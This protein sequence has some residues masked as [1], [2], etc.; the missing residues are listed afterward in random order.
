[1]PLNRLFACTYFQV[2]DKDSSQDEVYTPCE[3]DAIGAKKVNLIEIPKGCL[4]YTPVTTLE[5]ALHCVNIATPSKASN[6]SEI[7]K[8]VKERCDSVYPTPSRIDDEVTWKTII[9]D[10]TSIIF[11]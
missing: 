8:F 7:E 5:D 3:A 1:M 6:I 11:G 10:V 4:A 2:T 9:N